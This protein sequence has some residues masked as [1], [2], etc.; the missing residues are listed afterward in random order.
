[1]AEVDCPP[2]VVRFGIFE[3]DLQAGELRKNGAQRPPQAL[4]VQLRKPGKVNMRDQLQKRLRDIFVAV[5]HNLDTVVNKVRE[6]LDDSADNPPFSSRQ[7]RVGG[8]R[9]IATCRG[10]SLSRALGCSRTSIDRAKMTGREWRS[11][12]QFDGLARMALPTLH[13]GKSR[14]LTSRRRC[15]HRRCLRRWCRPQRLA[16]TG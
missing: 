2:Q 4:A 16:R 12:N 5:E 13:R 15:C 3:A 8:Y 9:F 1:V 6:V 14:K 10:C 11:S 7:S